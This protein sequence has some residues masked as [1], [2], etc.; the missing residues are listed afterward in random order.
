M[1]EFEVVME[2]KEGFLEKVM[3]KLISEGVNSWVKREEKHIL[4]RR[5]EL[6]KNKQQT[7]QP[8]PAKFDEPFE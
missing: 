5:K 7:N 1:G 8:V 4:G 2:V 6:L 3:I